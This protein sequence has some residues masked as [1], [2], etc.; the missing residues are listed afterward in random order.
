MN[1]QHPVLSGIT[2]DDG[3]AQCTYRSG[4]PESEKKYIER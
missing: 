3:Y 4:L 1:W 2:V